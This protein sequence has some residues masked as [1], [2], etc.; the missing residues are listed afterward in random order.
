MIEVRA[1]RER[2]EQ[3]QR[4]AFDKE[5][6]DWA[7]ER[8]RMETEREHKDQESKA[9]LEK[10]H[11]DKEEQQRQ[12]IEIADATEMHELIQNVLAQPVG[13]APHASG[14]FNVCVSAGCKHERKKKCTFG[15]CV[16]CCK[17]R[18]AAGTPRWK[19][20]MGMH[21]PG[22]V[23]PRVSY[24]FVRVVDMYAICHACVWMTTHT[25]S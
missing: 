13:V 16:G 22:H 6:T 14:M 21:N 18:P 1:G 7:L 10:E 8:E 25:K 23:S 20:N 11:Q 12:N 3:E 9:K 2:L 5:K 4:E 24:E 17:L 15:M 19:C